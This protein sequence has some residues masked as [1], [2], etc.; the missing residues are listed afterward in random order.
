MRSW[1]LPRKRKRTSHWKK[2][3]SWGR[4]ALLRISTGPA[5]PA[6]KTTDTVTEDDDDDGSVLP[7]LNY[8]KEKRRK[9]GPGSVIG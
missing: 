2:K 9:K 8:K 5:D 1:E 7:L 3:K 4:E 6:R